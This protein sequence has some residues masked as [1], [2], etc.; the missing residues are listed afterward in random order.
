MDRSHVG[1]SG[2]LRHDAPSG[3]GNSNHVLSSPG[4][5]PA[6]QC[7]VAALQDVVEGAVKLAVANAYASRE[8]R[9][10]SEV[11][12]GGKSE[13]GAAIGAAAAA[14]A[15]AA[16][17]DAAVAAKE[18]LQRE[19]E[20]L[21]SE[22]AELQRRLKIAEAPPAA[23]RNAARLTS[24]SSFECTAGSQT[25]E[26]SLQSTQRVCSGL[27]QANDAIMRTCMLRDVCFVAGELTY[28]AD[29]ELERT[30]PEMF[31]LQTLLNEK[32]V[33]L[34]VDVPT[35]IGT[36]FAYTGYLSGCQRNA[37]FLP[38]VVL[39]PRPA[40][41]PFHEDDRVYIMGELSHSQNYGHLLVDS[42]L[43]TLSV[44]DAF[45]LAPA[46][47]QYVGFTNCSTFAMAV[48][49]TPQ[50]PNSVVCERQV[51]RWMVPILSRPP[52]FPPHADGCFRRAIYGHEHQFSLGGMYLHRSAA[53]RTA[54]LQLHRALGVS[55]HVDFSV[56]THKVVVLQKVPLY[57]AEFLTT[58]CENVKRWAAAIEPQPDVECFKP[59]EFSVKKQLETISTATTVV[60]EHGSTSYMSMF[61]PPGSS[62]LILVPSVDLTPFKEVQVLL[63]NT[64]VSTCYITSSPPHCRPQRPPHIKPYP[65]NQFFLL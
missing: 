26:N 36:G 45:G 39:G 57:T 29:P 24:F 34:G 16:A 33:G 50:G 17:N 12:S 11:A 5:A 27:P 41:L 1:G 40:G 19:L 62:L 42:V 52:L 13:A 14:A 56:R 38:R 35:G 44:A 63:Y 48:G 18:A 4:P 23:S 21:R 58:M 7:D 28:Y 61:Q 3:D 2:G 55:P 64:D 15:A 32:P 65:R 51:E 6:T 37:R 60:A 53:M 49:E 9:R 43:P 46:Q 25:F 22:Y 31:R 20:A 10:Y 8:Q 30:T 47:T 54:R 59:G